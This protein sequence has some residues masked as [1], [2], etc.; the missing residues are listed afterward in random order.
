[1]FGGKKKTE[2]VGGKVSWISDEARRNKFYVH[3]K[4]SSSFVALSRIHSAIVSIPKCS[5]L[6]FPCRR[7]RAWSFRVSERFWRK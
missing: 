7:E 1:M 2:I 6:P 4:I 5:L 3:S